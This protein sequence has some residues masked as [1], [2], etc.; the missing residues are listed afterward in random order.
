MPNVVLMD[1]RMPVM[2]GI[3][4][5][6]RIVEAFP[7]VKVLIVTTYDEDDY[8]FDGLGRGASG[9]L[10]KDA[11]V[12]EIRSAVHAVAEGDAVLTPR[13]TKAV[14]ERGVGRTSNAS[15]ILHMRRRFQ[16]LSPREMQIAGLLAQGLSNKE[17]AMKMTIEVTSVRKNISRMLGKLEVRDRTQIAVTWY[18]AGFD[19]SHSQDT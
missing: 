4:A 3:E 17:I 5:T 11:T 19:A 16:R 9:F 2:D 8:A 18:Q 6:G 10:L 12:A 1:V 7:S 15:D 13:I 14:I